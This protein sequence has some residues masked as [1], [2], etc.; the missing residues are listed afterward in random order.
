MALGTCQK[1][2]TSAKVVSWLLRSGLGH[3]GKKTLAAPAGELCTSWPPVAVKAIST[4]TSSQ[5]LSS[6][7]PWGPLG[8]GS[9]FVVLQVR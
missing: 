5:E 6:G 9:V 2:L 7:G 4:L 3:A 1:V 8:P